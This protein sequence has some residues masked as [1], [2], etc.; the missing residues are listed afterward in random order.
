MFPFDELPHKIVLVAVV[1]CQQV[2]SHFWFS[3]SM[4]DVIVHIAKHVILQGL[5]YSL[6]IFHLKLLSFCMPRNWLFPFNFFI[7]LGR[8]TFCS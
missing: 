1:E 2:K 5:I 6:Y 4:C 8:H 7:F 3:V